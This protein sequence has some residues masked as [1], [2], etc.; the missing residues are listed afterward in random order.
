MRNCAICEA[1]ETDD[2]RLVRDHNHAT[3]IFR[4]MLCDQC[5]GYLSVYEKHKAGTR[6][7]RLKRKHI[8]WIA[9]NRQRIERHLTSNLGPFPP[10]RIAP[11]LPRA[12]RPKAKVEGTTP[13]QGAA[14]MAK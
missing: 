6:K 8:D 7:R 1:E 3:M 11:Y 12:T 2:R 9:H 14:E 10:E 5:N 4:G 13:N